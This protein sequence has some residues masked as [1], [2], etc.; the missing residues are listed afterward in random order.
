[1]AH[2]LGRFTAAKNL[3]KRNV[4]YKE[5]TLIVG[6]RAT[7]CGIFKSGKI[8]K[9]TLELKRTRSLT[10]VLMVLRLLKT[11]L[12]STQGTLAAWQPLKKLPTNALCCVSISLK[13]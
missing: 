10:F 8:L 1:M 12:G 5:S 13:I 3:R 11:K 4:R 9:D 6:T 2:L 7:T